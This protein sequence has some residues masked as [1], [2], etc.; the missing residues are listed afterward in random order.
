ML[1]TTVSALPWASFL[2]DLVLGDNVGGSDHLGPL[3]REHRGGLVKSAQLVQ[4]W[5]YQPSKQGQSEEGSKSRGEDISVIEQK[6]STM[7]NGDR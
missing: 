1:P 3:Y 5:V 7:M 2:A 4:L 6:Q